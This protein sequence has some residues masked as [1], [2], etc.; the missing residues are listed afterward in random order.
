MRLT[1]DRCASRKAITA[2]WSSTTKAG[3][4]LMASDGRRAQFAIVPAV[5]MQD[6]LGLGEGLAQHGFD[7]VAD[8]MGVAQRHRWVDDDMELDE[9]G[10][11]RRPR[12]QLVHVANLG[13]TARDLEDPLPLPVRQLAVHQHVERVAADYPGAV[14]E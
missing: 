5:D 14:N 7:A 1:G 9:L 11:A 4:R 2:D 6:D 10:E 8:H 3:C 12:T 13:V